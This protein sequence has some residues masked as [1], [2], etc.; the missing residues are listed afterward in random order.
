M[1][2]AVLTSGSLASPGWHVRDL[3]RA[4]N[5]V[6]DC[7]IVPCQWRSLGATVDAKG[8]SIFASD[9][10][11]DAMDAVLL[12]TMPAGSLE[13]IVLRMDI[14]NRLE[15]MGVKVLNKP[16]ALEMAVD[17]YLALSQMARAGVPVPATAVCQQFDDALAAFERLGSDVVLKPLFGSEGFGITRLTDADMAARAFSQ[18]QQMRGVMYLQA[19][20]DHGGQDL[21]L[22]VLAGR[23]IA[24][25]K[26]SHATDWRTNVARG[27][28]AIACEPEAAHVKLAIDAAA[29]CD[30]FI[31]GVDVLVD[32]A[33]DAWV[34]EV[35]AVPGWRALA[36]AT[37]VDV[38]AAW[39][40][41]VMA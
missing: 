3:Q 32:R 34:V 30:T 20:I 5:I 13:Q 15:A 9:V 22:L 23:V 18:L 12:R 8:Q 7:E 39:L 31:A 38:A 25:M 24:A 40:R 10:Q 16:R 26:R 4:A 2:I 33:G 17:K 6:G 11:L 27:A 14:A 21:R 35:N 41:E 36:E 37:G 29:A 1:R 28:S 19:F